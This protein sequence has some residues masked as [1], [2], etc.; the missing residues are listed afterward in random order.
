MMTTSASCHSGLSELLR[1]REATPSGI[2]CAGSLAPVTG[3]MQV[4]KRVAASS[5]AP[6]PA[7]DERPS[8][9]PRPGVTTHPRCSP[10]NAGHEFG[11]SRLGVRSDRLPR[12]M[13]LGTVARRSECVLLTAHDCRSSRWHVT[14]CDG[15]RVSRAQSARAAVPV[16]NWTRPAD[17]GGETGAARCR[18][19]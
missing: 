16:R 17:D 13:L 1:G 18:V 4:R 11:Y 12:A 6:A 10:S 5:F 19:S 8:I 14:C 3:R 7:S 15:A 9:W 2:R